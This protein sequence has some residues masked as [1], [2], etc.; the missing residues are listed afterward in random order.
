MKKSV[1]K[2]CCQTGLFYGLLPHTFCIAFVL[3]SVIGATAA[4]AFFKKFLLLPYFFEILIGISCLF[5]TLS[6]I[7]YLKKNDCL[8][9]DKIKTKW[10][11]LSILYG[12]TIAIN[13]FFFL[14]VFPWVT[15]LNLRSRQPVLA[16]KNS[17]VSVTLAVQ[18]PCSGH[19]PLI[20]DEIKKLPGIENVRFELPNKFIVN[21][22]PA[23]VSG[24]K[25][26]TLEIFRSYPVK[27]A[28]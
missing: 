4:S 22:D 23:L 2:S 3:A 15:N 12:T 27:P 16:Q 10:K 28:L 13:L 5:A 26:M 1:E 18:I 24:E 11:Y 21:Y 20:A 17:L 8:S 7:F 25:I 9:A 19:A 6:A 14:V